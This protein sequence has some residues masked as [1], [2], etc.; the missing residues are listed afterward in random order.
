M[1]TLC[2]LFHFFFFFLPLNVYSF[3]VILAY[4]ACKTNT[5]TCTGLNIHF[6]WYSIEFFK[7][8]N[9]LVPR[10]S[11]FLNIF[12]FL[13]I[14]ANHFSQLNRPS[15]LYWRCWMFV[16]VTWRRVIRSSHWSCLSSS[17]YGSVD[18]TSCHGLG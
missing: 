17:T 14:K 9:K 11:L 6:S 16:D 2:F 18:C 10:S 13:I 5:S 8:R 4:V 7:S 15:F 3:S 1:E 12:S